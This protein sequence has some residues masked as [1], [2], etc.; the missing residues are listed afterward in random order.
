MN[1]NERIKHESILVRENLETQYSEDTEGDVNLKKSLEKIK[2]N[3]EQ[4]MDEIQNQ[5]IDVI[6][7]RAED[8]K[9]RLKAYL[10]GKQK[11]QGSVDTLDKKMKLEEESAQKIITKIRTRYKS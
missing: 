10:R 11:A 5:A 1:K 4:V 2:R 3:S 9:K 6:A 8:K 7:Q